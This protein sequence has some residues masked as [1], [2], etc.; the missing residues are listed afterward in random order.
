MAYW[1]MKTE[2]QVFAFDDF[3][4]HPL[5]R[6]G[7]EGVRNYQARNFM[8]DQFR[9]GDGVLIYHSS[10]PEPGVMG[11]AQV[12]REAYPDVTAVDPE[13]PYFDPK[14]V[15]AGASRWLMVDLE[16]TALFANPVTLKSMRQDPR[17]AQMLL[18]KPGQR[19]SIQPI[20]EEEWQLICGLGQPQ[21]LKKPIPRESE[22]PCGKPP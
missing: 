9:Q 21:A 20:T 17:L 5:N 18:L 3:L 4:K 10:C 1:L 15:T 7:W 11:L 2:P 14:S 12:V 8:R 19:L 16:A 13:S 22:A 6:A